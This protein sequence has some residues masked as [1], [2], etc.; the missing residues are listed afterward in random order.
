MELHELVERIE[1]WKNRQAGNEESA[2][3]S[4]PVQDSSMAEE[5]LASEPEAFQEENT[6]N[7]DAHSYAEMHDEAVD[8]DANA[9]SEPGATYDPEDPI[10]FSS[11]DEDDEDENENDFNRIS[12]T[13][14]EEVK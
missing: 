14:F 9:E 4:I 2:R 13:D 3:V 10:D 11:K 12:L 7:F 5:S 8:D 1:R 6:A